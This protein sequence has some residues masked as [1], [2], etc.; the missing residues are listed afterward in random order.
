MTTTITGFT[1]AR[2]KQIE[3]ATVIGGSVVG[4]NLILE[5]FNGT[6]VNAG[7]VK[8]SQGIQG[9]PGE[10][11]AAQLNAAVSDLQDDI[12]ASTPVGTIT[13]YAGASAPENWALAQ[14]QAVSRTTYSAL[15]ALI[16]TTYGTGDGSTTFNLPDL[17][18]R[19]V[20]GLGTAVWAN[21]RNKKGGSKDAP[22]VTHTHGMTHDHPTSTT[23]SDSH[24]H[25]ATHDHTASSASAGSH[26]HFFAARINPNGS[27]DLGEPMISNSTGTGVV[28]A[29][30]AGGAHTHGVTVNSKSMS[31]G[32]DSHTHTAA[33]ANSSKTATD[34]PS[35]AVAAADA[36]LV[37]YIVLNYIIKVL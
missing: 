23:S 34:A 5:K 26:A 8:G 4:D 31:T 25:T 27:G 20:A 2:M 22:V 10:V 32:S 6:T 13:M 3:D 21:A 12:V 28:K 24:S 16:G 19:F 30:Q 18:E 36:N 14:G 35:G 17:R 1:A 7:P 11:S 33:I 15:F 9:V 29:T 37:P